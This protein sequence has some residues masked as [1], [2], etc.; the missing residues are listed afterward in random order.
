MF[1]PFSNDDFARAAHA[2][3]MVAA[4]LAGAA[5]HAD[6]RTLA[7]EQRAAFEH[8]VAAAERTQR[9]I[10]AERFVNPLRASRRRGAASSSVIAMMSPRAA[11]RPRF[12]AAT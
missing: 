10:V 2:Q 1:A 12:S 11:S 4:D 3:V 8:P 7:V 9:R 6:F 5:N